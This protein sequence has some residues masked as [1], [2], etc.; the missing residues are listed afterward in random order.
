MDSSAGPGRTG[1]IRLNTERVE[2]RGCI[3]VCG[4]N[5]SF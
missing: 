2:L 4:G 1:V 5:G 3:S